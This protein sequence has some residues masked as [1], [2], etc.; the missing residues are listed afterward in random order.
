MNF[1][2]T[3]GLASLDPP[4]SFIQIQE[5]IG[6]ENVK[7]HRLSREPFFAPYVDTLKGM[8]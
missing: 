7:K 5:L 4:Y 8:R 6:P 1:R 2:K 3:V